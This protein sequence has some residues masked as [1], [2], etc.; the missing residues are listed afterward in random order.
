[1]QH[2]TMVLLLLLSQNAT[3]DHGTAAAITKCHNHPTLHH[4]Q[5]GIKGGCLYV[6]QR[7]E[8]N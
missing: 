6:Y 3:Q 7:Y 5:T 8:I 2:K 4:I 1:M